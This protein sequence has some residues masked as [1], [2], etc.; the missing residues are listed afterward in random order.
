MTVPIIE[1]FLS[2]S[3]ECCWQMHVSMCIHARIK[4]D[5]ILGV[6]LYHSLP[7]YFDIGTLI[8][9]SARLAAS[10]HQWSCVSASTRLGL[11]ATAKCIGLHLASYLGVRDL[12]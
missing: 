10:K 6:L 2:Q 9:L 12:N 11:Q 7:Y 4:E 5:V 3:R 1:S 8:E